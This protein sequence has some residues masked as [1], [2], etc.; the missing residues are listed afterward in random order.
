MLVYI[1]GP[2][3]ADTLEKRQNNVMQAI[4][5]GIEI[6]ARGH[7]PFIPHLTHFVDLRVQELELELGWEEYMRWDAPW[8]ELCDAILYLGSSPGADLELNRAKKLGKLV[9]L[10]VM[11]LPLILW[12]DNKE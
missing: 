4:D 3:T 10:S 6:F 7:F 11:D 12:I 5:A 8:L 9:F 2:Y 1:A